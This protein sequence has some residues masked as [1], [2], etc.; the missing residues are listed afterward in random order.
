M[1]MGFCC[2]E[3][4][5]IPRQGVRS[6]GTDLTHSAMVVLGGFAI[7][8]RQTPARDVLETYSGGSTKA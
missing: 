2:G 6:Q 5:S 1:V 4:E 7:P 8:L 3:N